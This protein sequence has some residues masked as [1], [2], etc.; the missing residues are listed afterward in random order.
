MTSEALQNESSKQSDAKYDQWQAI[1]DYAAAPSAKNAEVVDDN[2]QYLERC[3]SDQRFLKNCRESYLKQ[4]EP[5]SKSYATM[6]SLK[7]KLDEYVSDQLSGKNSEQF[8]ASEQFKNYSQY[9]VETARTKTCKLNGSTYYPE[10]STNPVLRSPQSREKV[11]ANVYKP[12]SVNRVLGNLAK[13]E[14]GYKTCLK[15]IDS[16]MQNEGHLTQGEL[17]A[18]GDYLY[19]GRRLETRLAKD[20]ACYLYNESGDNPQL[21][22]STPVIGALANYFT[23]NFTRDPRVKDSQFVIANYR[24]KD[25]NTGALIPV[26][27]GVS[28][29]NCCVLEQ[30]HFLKASLSSD[31]SLEKSR[32]NTINDLYALM[33]VSF[34]EL[35]HDYQR[36]QADDKNDDSS[37]MAYILNQVLRQNKNCCFPK[38]DANGNLIK[39]DYYHANHDCDEME[40]QADEE[41]WRQCRKFIHEH[42]VQYNWKHKN[43][44]RERVASS[45]WTKCKNNEREVE[46]RRTFALKVDENGREIP[47]IQYDTNNLAKAIQ[48]RPELLSRYPQ[49]GEYFDQSGKIR[50]EILFNKKIANLENSGFDTYTDNFGVEFAA[51]ALTDSENADNVLAYIKNDQNS[52]TPEQVRRFITNQWNLLHQNALRTRA[53]GDVNFQN[54]DETKTRG[55]DTDIRTLRQYYLK[56]Y[57]H[58]MYNCMHM[59]SA[60]KEKCPQ[61]TD[62][63]DSWTQT[64]YA[65][66]YKEL[67]KDVALDKGYTEQV[68]A[69]YQETGD[70]LLRVMADSMG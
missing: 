43:G 51:Y 54:Y 60:L 59:A 66:Y 19:S 46:A 55:K 53:L 6:L 3:L 30:N 9:I 27:I 70:K 36:L 42:E 28:T 18:A 41:A 56:Q 48:A 52:F 8:A 20:F 65:S 63:I 47:Y 4:Y 16:R 57:L 10:L 32:T 22:P 49:L 35:T 13:S 26:N 31:R 67:S 39:T 44:D 2:R 68:R 61:A 15:E 29:S 62:Y 58:Q 38:T 24:S 64:S 45:H 17:D 69:R 1:A 40:I 50:P 7:T 21:R 37:G 11:I 34:H 23:Q 33:I 5:D 14:V 25:Q 12:E